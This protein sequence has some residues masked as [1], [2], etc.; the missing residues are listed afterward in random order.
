MEVKRSRPDSA[1]SLDS[2]FER[3]NLP[4]SAREQCDE[5]ARAWMSQ[6]ST[7]SAGG[8]EKQRVVR[9]VPFQGYCSYTLSIKHATRD[10]EDTPDSSSHDDESGSVL[11]QFR[12]TAHAIDVDT[13]AA[14][15]RVYGSLA[16]ETKM[17]GKLRLRDGLELVAYS[18]SMIPGISLL[19]LTARAV[20]RT[21]R[22]EAPNVRRPAAHRERLVRDLARFYATGLRRP[23]AEKPSQQPP[24]R[25]LVGSSLRTRL[26]TMRSSLPPRF[27]PFIASA[28]YNLEDIENKLPWVLTH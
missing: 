20:Q 17:I 27:H 12:P 11:I 14:A 4:S 19:D 22:L 2:F 6:S 1:I 5:F 3:H 13:A 24:G 15:R 28:L 23:H 9:P 26:E 7:G 8:D 18:L 25:G 16:P 21:P 10:N